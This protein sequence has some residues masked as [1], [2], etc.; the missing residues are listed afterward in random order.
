M[1]CKRRRRRKRDGWHDFDQQAFTPHLLRCL[2]RIRS[3]FPSLET[4]KATVT[5]SSSVAVWNPIP[6]ISSVSPAQIKVGAFTLTI[7]GT[8]FVSGAVVAFGVVPSDSDIRF[9]D[10]DRRRRAPRPTP[11]IGSVTVV[12]ANPN[13]GEANS[14]SMNAQVAEQHDAANFRGRGVAIPRADY[15]WATHSAILRY[16]PA[17]CR[18]F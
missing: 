13:P 1:V 4:A 18:A 17:G 8:N 7:T 15:I 9:S 14:N 6:H 2:R 16:K 10:P 11:E 12:V 5:G 3:R